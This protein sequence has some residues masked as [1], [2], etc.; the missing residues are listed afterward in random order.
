MTSRGHSCGAPYFLWKLRVSYLGGNPSSSWLYQCL[1]M[2]TSTLVVTWA[3][4][5]WSFT[6]LTEV[7][8]YF[9]KKHF[10]WSCMS[11]VNSHHW[12]QD[13]WIW[14]L[15]VLIYKILHRFSDPEGFFTVNQGAFAEGHC[16]QSIADYLKGNADCTR[17]FSSPVKSF[18]ATLHDSWLELSTRCN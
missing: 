7:C 14:C 18:L 13:H 15:Q 5:Q 2:W 8:D 9:H 10:L 4:K 17:W 1:L 11:R 16:L 3:L 12:I 6:S